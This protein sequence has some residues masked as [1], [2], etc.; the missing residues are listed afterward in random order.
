M[1]ID[2]HSHV[3]LSEFDKDRS[4][5]EERAR[6]EKIANI[7]LP[8][9]DASSI[10]SLKEL[11]KNKDGF[12]K[13]MMGL[14]PG[15]VKENYKEELEIIKAEL[16]S[17]PYIAVGEIG[18]DLYWDKTFIKEQIRVFKEQIEW[19]LDLDLPIVIHAR[20]SFPEIFNV[21]DEYKESNLKGVFHCFSGGPN[22]LT[23]ALSYSNFMLGIGGVLTFKNSGLDKTLLNADLDRLI[24][25]TDAPY[26]AP[27]PY[28]GKRNEPSYIRLVANKLAEL[29][30]CSVET[31]EELTSNNA[32][33][34]FNFAI[35]E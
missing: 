24:L 15:S 5:V 17:E 6:A 26:L 18:I 7:L 31:I 21:L 20:D 3:Y 33:R 23:K 14:H 13:G 11:C 2:T 8:N 4:E 34:L 9:I 10:S 32:I 1:L 27:T 22:E 12:Y 29:K 16:Y 35:D 30:G 19:A 28:R 25:E